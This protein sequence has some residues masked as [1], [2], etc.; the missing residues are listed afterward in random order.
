MGRERAEGSSPVMGVSVSES[1]RV[2]LGPTWGRCRL[3]RAAVARGQ[4]D[5]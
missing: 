2:A 5:R 1:T 4:W 3:I